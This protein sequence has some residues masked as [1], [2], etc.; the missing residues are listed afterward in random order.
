MTTGGPRT[1]GARASWAKRGAF[2]FAAAVL[3]GV[4]VVIGRATA[5]DDEVEAPALPE[6]CNRTLD[7][8][9]EL[10]RHSLDALT[11]AR[12]AVAGAEEQAALEED[13]ASAQARVRGLVAHLG[14]VRDLCEEQ[15]T[16]TSTTSTTAG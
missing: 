15:R 3:L 9:D 14:G 12:D 10:G 16:A 6:V 13:L 4:G 1:A 2:V 5:P 11:E 7:V 8:A